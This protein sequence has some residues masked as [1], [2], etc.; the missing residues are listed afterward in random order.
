MAD[1]APRCWLMSLNDEF[2]VE[3]FYDYLSQGKLMGAKCGDCGRLLVPP[4]PVCDKCF[5]QKMSWVEL[6]PRGKILTFSEVHV[7]NDEFQPIAPYVVAVV[8]L[9]D[10][11]RLGGIVKGARRTDIKIG[12]PVVLEIDRKRS[13]KWPYWPR[14]YFTRA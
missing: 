1:V 14:Y 2:T 13:Q 9:E 4:R 6:S 5:S 12:D 8:Q 10:N 11:V 3:Q 7:A